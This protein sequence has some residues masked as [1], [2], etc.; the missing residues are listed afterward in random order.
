MPFDVP[1]STLA[2]RTTLVAGIVLA[3]AVGIFLFW[4]AASSFF[5]I[6]GGLLLASIF[7][8]L[9]RPLQRLGLPRWA[10]LLL[11][12]L[13]LAV[14]LAGGTAYG[15]MALVQEV[16]DLSGQIGGQVE[17]LR[18][19]AADAGLPV[20]DGQ[21]QL[22]QLLPGS[23]RV[24][25]RA[26]EAGLAFLGGLGNVAV[27]IFIAVFVAWQPGLYKR[28]LV[29]LFPKA[30]RPRIAET[31][32]DAHRRLILWVAGAAIS[33]L[34]IFLVSL[35]GLWLIGMPGAFLLA[36]Q[37]GLLAFIPT[38]GPVVAGVPIIL[39]G[40]AQSPT[41][42]L[43]GLGVYLLIQGIE[44]N[45]T[46]PI[47]QRWTSALPPALTLGAQLVFGALF[48]LVGV[49]LAVPALAVIMVFVEELYV[50]DTLG[51]PVPAPSG[52]D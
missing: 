12:I 33:M 38:I 50:K 5:L 42:A 49:I 24:V 44:S 26:S 45:V 21:M 7:D 22:D 11:V 28:G 16:R 48:G 18:G 27:L 1:T 15:G 10:A 34:T 35:L 2:A 3:M 23:G 6:F 37:A 47:A 31:L 52:G 39:A 8:A 13:V 29:S 30:K 9:S 4:T 36:L 43:W 19:W 40:L 14:L 32:D 46:A 17:R 41:M 25:S 51:G 20:G